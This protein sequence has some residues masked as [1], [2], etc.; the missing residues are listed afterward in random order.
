VFRE[1]VEELVVLL[2]LPPDDVR[3]Q[4]QGK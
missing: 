4:L 3:A 1:A 2:N